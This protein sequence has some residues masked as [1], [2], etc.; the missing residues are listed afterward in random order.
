MKYHRI[1]A[2]AILIA[3][4]MISCS[5]PGAGVPPEETASLPPNSISTSEQPTLP[6]EP[7]TTFPSTNGEITF[8]SERDGKWQIIDMFA[9]G[10]HE[11]SLT[12]TYG[13]FSYPAWAPDGNSL[14]MRVE[15]DSGNGIATM[16][17]SQIGTDLTGEQP[18]TITSAFSDAPTWAPD[19]SQLIY[20]T[21]G[22]F[23][24]EFYRYQFSDGLATL[25]TGLSPWARDPKWSPDGQKILFSDDVNN[26]GNS[27]IFVINVDG[28][29]LT[30]LTDTPYYEG[31]PNWSPD[32]KRIVFSASPNDNNSDLYIMNLDGSGLFHLTLDP[33]GEVDPAWS[34]DG[35]RIAFVS[36]RHEN[37]D[38]NYEIYVINA[39]GTDEMRLTNNH[40][41]D[42][43]PV[44][45]P[46]STA[47]GQA[48]CNA[49]GSFKADVTIPAGTRFTNQAAFT[50][51]WRL[52]NSGNCSWTPNGYRL[53][54]T[55]GDQ[56]GGPTNG[57]MPGAIQ[58][59]SEVDI[60]IPFTAPSSP[61]IYTSTWQLWDAA[62]QPVDD[63]EGNPLI[64]SLA[65]EV[66]ADGISVLPA[67]LY[68]LAGEENQRQIWRME[69][70]GQTVTQ[71]TNEPGGIS[72]FE[73]NPM[74]GQLAYISAY[75]LVLYNPVDNSRKVLE[76]GDENSQPW[77]PA[78]SNDGTRL[79]YGW[80]GI[81]LYKLAEGTNEIILTNNDTM[82]PS[83][84]RIY[85]PRSWSPDDSKLLVSIGYWEWGG[86][87]IVS[88]PDGT[89]LSEFEYGDSG[90]WSNDSQYWYSA[91]ASEPGMLE[92]VPGLFRIQSIS[93]ATLQPLFTGEMAWWPKQ[94]EDGRL[95]YFKGEPNLTSQEQYDISLIKVDGDGVSNMQV[96]LENIFTL[97]PS[98]FSEATW[99]SDGS[100]IA[101]RLIHQPSKTGE[102]ILMGTTGLPPTWLLPEATNLRFGK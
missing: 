63:E 56:L 69:M 72:H 52:E 94:T 21:S 82:D 7:P 23:G 26:D 35:T 22:N 41:I 51:V 92:T 29:G 74:D 62:D 46:G 66:L 8:A 10:S 95:V 48:E 16:P 12:A 30:R 3:L 76:T 78:W 64:V 67:R 84:R 60:A 2:I 43:W 75:Q 18:V 70:D 37:F 27:D 11:T 5:L 15:M 53:R 32:G 58:P 4:S 45:R 100:W 34:P 89:L 93:G 19:G 25:L 13:A 14:A 98:G 9:D 55:E 86:L 57:F 83:L 81:H 101:T 17:V 91:N 77:G 61:G 80:N 59:G 42:R 6:P 99:S 65:I 33:A 96:L 38:S 31:N 47:N 49:S 54:F 24:W 40:F 85:T 87:G 36:T 1:I 88:I 102:I 39:D 44:W 50:K 20:I 68:Y 71:L 90:I 97:T 28:S 73:V 79:A